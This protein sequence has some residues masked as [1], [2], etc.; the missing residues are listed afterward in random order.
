MSRGGLRS[1][2]FKPGLSGNP[3]GRPKRPD[4]VEAHRIIT[5]VKA[6]ARSHTAAAFETL[7]EAMQ[8]EKAP[9][10]A[11]IS[12]AIA[13]LDRAWGRPLQA[14]EHAGAVAV[15]QTTTSQLDISSLSDDE[16]DALERALRATVL[17]TVPAAH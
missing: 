17:S 15:E 2:S 16:L 12:A 4:T 5:D 6:A 8:S 1:T 9:W 3:G 7:V 10:A 11:R 14:V 13:V